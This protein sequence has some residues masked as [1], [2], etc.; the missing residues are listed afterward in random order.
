MNFDLNAE[1]KMLKESAKDFFSKEVDGALV[2]TLEED[3]KGYSPKH[4]EKMS[5]LGWL[6]LLVPEAYGGEG[7]DLL[8]MAIVLEEMGS[9]AM[10]GPLFTSSVVSALLL[11]EA[12]SEEQKKKFLP[13]LAGGKKIF[14]LAWNEET[15]ATSPVGIH[16]SAVS[17]DGQ[18]VLRGRKLFV[19]YAHISDHIIVA[20][21]TAE[22]GGNGDA[23]I[24]LFLVDR[25]AQGVGIDVIATSSGE[26]QCEVRLDQVSVSPDRL[27]GGL[28]DGWKIL[29]TVFRKSAVA[30]CAEMIGGAAKV[31]KMT[32]E[33][34]CK[35]V[36]FGRPIGSFQAVQH[37]CANMKMLL[38]ASVVITYRACW[39]IRQGLPWEKD[40]SMCKAWVGESYKKLTALGHQVMGGFGCM[41]EAD[42]QLF[43]RRAAWA[44]TVFGN[45][46]HHREA[47]ARFMGL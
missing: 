11:L 5:K 17:K 20:A 30:K 9:V 37:H 44:D 8:D 1:Q 31:L 32:V 23:G 2:R 33:Y 15:A 25:S 14:T 12:G 35:R 36:Q 16:A 4:W 39:L 6:G 18:Y 21:R 38:D 46:S 10:P 41:E 7:M 24:S 34:A 43:Y 45:G 28:H 22:P 27:L 42:H 40:A 26:K 47:V 29:D 3:E 19:P 13:G